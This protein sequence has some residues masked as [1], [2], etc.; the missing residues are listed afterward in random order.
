MEKKGNVIYVPIWS[1][2]KKSYSPPFSDRADRLVF[3]GS[4]VTY[5]SLQLAVYMGFSEI[6]LIGMDHNFPYHRNRDGNIEENDKSIPVHFWESAENNEDEK[7]IDLHANYQEL[8]ENAYLEAKKYC[9]K[10]GRVKIYNVTRGGKLEVFERKKLE[11][12]L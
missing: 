10:V 11:D 2:I 9:E 8:A 4:M 7:R 3:D 1:K 12:V 6:Y 5:L